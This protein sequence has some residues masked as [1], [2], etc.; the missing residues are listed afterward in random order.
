MIYLK[1][2]E[3]SIVPHAM[4]SPFVKQMLNS[5]SITNKIILQ[6]WKDLVTV[7]LK[8]GPQLLSRT[9]EEMRIGPMNNEVRIEVLKSPKTNFLEKMIMQMFKNNLYVITIRLLYGVQY[10]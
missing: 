8:P 2:L 6:D 3:K 4:H 9:S 7:V 5:W 10:L 1:R